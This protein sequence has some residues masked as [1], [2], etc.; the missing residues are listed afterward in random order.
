VA[1]TRGACRAGVAFSLQT[2]VRL[3]KPNRSV[4]RSRYPYYDLDEDEDDDEEE[5]EEGFEE[6][7]DDE[8]GYESD[9]SCPPL[10]VPYSQSSKWVLTDMNAAHCLL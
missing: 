10:P 3:L 4:R 9:V 5:L 6:E 7:E 8:E 2:N 1:A